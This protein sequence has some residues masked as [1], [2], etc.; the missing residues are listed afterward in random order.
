M[1]N[2]I[3]IIQ[4]AL[5]PLNPAYILFP[6]DINVIVFF[7]GIGKR[8]NEVLAIAKPDVYRA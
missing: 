4:M 2:K 5:S 7:E 8:P 1:D 3:S 6:I